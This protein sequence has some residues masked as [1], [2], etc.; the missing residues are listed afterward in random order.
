MTKLQTPVVVPIDD[1]DSD[2]FVPAFLRRRP[3][4]YEPW[5]EKAKAKEPIPESSTTGKRHRRGVRS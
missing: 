1:E 5:T 3:I 4:P 2:D